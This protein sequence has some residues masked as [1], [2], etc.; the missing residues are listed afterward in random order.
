MA[1]SKPTS[2]ALFYVKSLISQYLK[3]FSMQS[4]LFP[5]R[6]ANLCADSPYHTPSIKILDAIWN[7][8][9]QHYHLNLRDPFKILGI[10]LR[11]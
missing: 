1:D 2:Y 4:G 6:L 11:K 10:I 8:T 3:N 9:C 7:F 5:F